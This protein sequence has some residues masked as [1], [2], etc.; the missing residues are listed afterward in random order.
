LVILETGPEEK[1]TATAVRKST[2]A[3]TKWLKRFRRTVLNT[4]TRD[5]SP[6]TWD[7]LV[8]ADELKAS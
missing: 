4:N 2:K 3:E 5:N 8:N 6:T 1:V 7:F